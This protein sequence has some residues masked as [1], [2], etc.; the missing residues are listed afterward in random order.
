MKSWKSH[1]KRLKELN[2]KIIYFNGEKEAYERLVSEYNYLRKLTP[3]NI[4]SDK[5]LFSEFY[6][7]NYYRGF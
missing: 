7:K 3:A 5:E 2:E 4:Y 6:V 1:K